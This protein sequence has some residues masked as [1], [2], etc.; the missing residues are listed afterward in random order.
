MMKNTNSNLEA[1]IADRDEHAKKLYRYISDTARR[2]DE[3]SAGCKQVADLFATTLEVYRQKLR[4]NCEKLILLEPLAYGRKGLELLWRKAYY[5]TVAAAKRLRRDDQHDQHVLAHLAC[6]VGHFHQLIARIQLETGLRLESDVDYPPIDVEGDSVRNAVDEDLIQWGRG[7]IH[8]CLIYLGDLCRYRMELI[9]DC[10]ASPASRYYLQAATLD[11]AAG[12]PHNQLGT[13]YTGRNHDLDSVRSYIHCLSCSL[14]FEGAEGN[15]IRSLEKNAALGENPRNGDADGTGQKATVKRFISQFLLLTDY[16]FFQKEHH[17]AEELCNGTLRDLKECLSFEMLPLPDIERNYEEYAASQEDEAANPSY[18]NG[19][20]L[21]SVVEICLFCIDKLDESDRTR[22]FTAKAFLLALFSQLLQKLLQTLHSFGF[23]DPSVKKN[24]YVNGWSN[25]RTAEPKIDYRKNGIVKKEVSS[26]P[27]EEVKLNGHLLADSDDEAKRNGTGEKAQIKKS[28]ALKSIRRRRRARCSDSSDMSAEEEDEVGV[29]VGEDAAVSDDDSVASSD[30]SADRG[31]DSG[32]SAGDNSEDEAKSEAEEPELNGTKEKMKL[33]VPKMVEETKPSEN[34]VEE[35]NEEQISKF[36]EG[37]NFLPTIKL[38]QDWVIKETHLVV[39][40]GRLGDA[41]FQ[42]IVDVLNVFQVNFCG[43]HSAKLVA[44]RCATLELVREAAA[45]LGDGY[46]NAPLPEDARLRGTALCR[47]ECDAPEWASTLRHERNVLEETVMRILHIIDFGHLI[48]RVVPC[49]HYNRS[50][51]IFYIKKTNATKKTG[52]SLSK[53]GSKEW[54]DSR[55]KRQ[56]VEAEHQTGGEGS[57]VRALGKLWLAAQV[58][59]LESATRR[60]PPPPYLALD[61]TALCHHLPAVKHL[62]AARKFILLVPTVVVQSI[63]ELKKE[64]SSARAAI[65]WLETQLRGGSRF[66][67][68]Q[69]P[70]ETRVLHALRVP[71]K[72]SREAHTFLQIVQFCHYFVAEDDRSAR[73]GEGDAAGTEEEERERGAT[74]VVLLTGV[75][76]T[77]APPAECKDFSYSGLARSA[78]V[79]VEH[80]EDFYDK[81][82]HC[83]HRNKKR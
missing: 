29:F 5:E 41:L 61:A 77:E 43:K 8:S 50:L 79:A 53:R 11:L 33:E 17:D 40:C 10:D 48:T 9:D 19:D 22:A 46:R 51:Q 81:W 68:T 56:A 65:R 71:R 63:D 49:V 70:A 1:D 78:G 27:P 55:Q 67:R 80:I 66:L 38:I 36:M 47:F 21:H 30:L 15:L 45:V 14:P 57:L 75:R 24:K 3:R 32:D 18:L 16:W 64:S 28:N 72:L 13:L 69:R 60:A 23:V 35:L 37:H 54:K 74:V 42:S 6:G 25:R 7:V 26:S 44:Q 82:R 73:G 4:D 83:F 34:A 62:V 59:E 2:I 12:M 58:R 31:D 76:P 52:K 20:I 39:S